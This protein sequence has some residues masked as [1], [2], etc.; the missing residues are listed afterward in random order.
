MVQAVDPIHRL[1]MGTLRQRAILAWLECF[2]T[3]FVFGSSHA[4]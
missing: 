3:I 4:T 2:R 1:A